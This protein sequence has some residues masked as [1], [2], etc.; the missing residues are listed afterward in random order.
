MVEAKSS[1]VLR[2]L[3]ASGE[4]GLSSPRCGVSHQN[5]FEQQLESA[6]LNRLRFALPPFAVYQPYYRPS[7]VVDVPKGFPRIQ[8]ELFTSEPF[9]GM[10]VEIAFFVFAMEQ[11]NYIQ[12]V[13]ARQLQSNGWVFDWAS[14]K[15][16]L[17]KSALRV[18]T[19]R[20]VE[21]R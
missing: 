8:G 5:R 19:R 3:Q 17:Q 1:A 2:S 4:F 15:W 11:N 10:P 18:G 6:V 9:G 21:S 12:Y 7:E 20:R 16:Y 14:R 13:A